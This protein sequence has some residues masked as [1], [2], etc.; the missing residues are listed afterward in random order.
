MWGLSG[1]PIC[2]FWSDPPPT[3]LLFSINQAEMVDESKAKKGKE[4][5]V[6]GS[7][8]IKVLIN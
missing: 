5:H 8:L 2:T 1:L 7:G 3:Q 4:V 6:K